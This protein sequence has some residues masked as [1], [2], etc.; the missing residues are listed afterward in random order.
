MGPQ[1]SGKGTQ[2]TI[3]S[4]KLS[5][6]HISTGEIL[7]TAEGRMKKRIEKKTS[8]GRLIK[9]KL[10][11]RLLK[12]RISQPDCNEGFILDGYP[13]NL[14][15]SKTLSKKIG[16]DKIIEIRISNKIA[17]KRLT[18]RRHCGKCGEGYN[19]NVKSLKPKN[20]EICN[21]CKIKLSKR[22]DDNKEA[23]KK[24]LNTYYKKTKPL[25]EKYQEKVI[26]VDGERSINKVANEILEKLKKEN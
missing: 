9:N 1:G 10:M 2:A 14:K 22:K 15:Q 6:P 13:R 11:L 20:N 26:S 19:L 23:I 3:L 7:R 18:G 25:L 12:K 8:K 5:I 16:F 21:K 4:K 17:I 24:R